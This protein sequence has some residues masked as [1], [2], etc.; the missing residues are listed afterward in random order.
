MTEHIL[1]EAKNEIQVKLTYDV[2]RHQWNYKMSIELATEHAEKLSEDGM[3]E[4]LNDLQRDFDNWIVNRFQDHCAEWRATKTV[5]GRDP[6]DEYRRHLRRD[7]RGEQDKPSG[8][9][10]TRS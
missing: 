3:S 2:I 10:G 7:N 4:V 8:G 6:H 1:K 9:N 5:L